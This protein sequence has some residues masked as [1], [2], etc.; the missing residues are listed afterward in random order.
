[1]STLKVSIER[2]RSVQPHPNA[3]RLDLIE[4]LGWQCVVSKD[5]FKVGDL[6]VY[7]PI[8]SVLPQPVEQAIFGIDSKV[9]LE[10]SRVRTIKLRGA[11]SQ[12]LAV[13]PQTLISLLPYSIGEGDEVTEK[14][15]VTKYEPPASGTLTVAH[16][17]TSKKQTNPN[18]RKYTEIENGKNY[19]DL[20]QEG[21]E[22]VVTEK[23]H[24]T[25]FR[26][27]RVPFS[28]STLWKKILQFLGLAP[29]FEFVYGSHNVQLQDK[30][31]ASTYYDKN[32][33]AEAVVKYGL[34]HKDNM[35]YIPDGYVV[36]GE[37][38]GDGI[39]KGYNYGLG[40]R[41]LVL[42][43]IMKDGEYLDFPDF[44]K[45]ATSNY[46]P[47][48]PVLYVGPYNKEKIMSMVSGPS[49]LC[50]DQKVREGI[51]VK[52]VKE[53]TT[54]MGRKILKLINPDYL[55]DKNNSEWH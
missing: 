4:V 3:D 37:V 53:Q 51:V 9:K 39:Q 32:V 12:G 10:K 48:V 20:F 5:S 16:V 46:W 50:P 8:D 35:F 47:T 55:L 36:Y 27:G 43:D 24:G 17:K 41:A 14:L 26:A 15:G 13:H 33:Y 38:Y 6:C 25:N 54:H 52:A 31:L 2:V 18:F 30:V 34:A 23:I 44:D 29:K 42:F 11:V 49:V 1:M 7:F 28:A 21:E 19:P 40:E 45:M 22:V